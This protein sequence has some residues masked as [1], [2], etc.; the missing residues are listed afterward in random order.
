MG[1]HACMKKPANTIRLVAM[2]GD[3]RVHI[4]TGEIVGTTRHEAYADLLKADIAEFHRWRESIGNP[5]LEDGQYGLDDVS[6]HL[7]N[8]GYEEGHPDSR[9]I[10]A[11]N[12]ESDQIDSPDADAGASRSSTKKVSWPALSSAQVEVRA[13]THCKPCGSCPMQ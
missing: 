2:H 11:E 13:L 3:I 6:W 12:W 7:V 1:E 4:E 9:D 8:G 10:T 5:P